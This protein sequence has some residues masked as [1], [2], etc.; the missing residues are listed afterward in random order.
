MFLLTV[1]LGQ[2]VTDT[3]LHRVKIAEEKTQEQQEEGERVH[4][5][6]KLYTIH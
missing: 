3:E 5:R 6:T 4:A 2:L 1:V